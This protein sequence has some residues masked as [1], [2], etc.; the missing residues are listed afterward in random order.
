MIWTFRAVTA[1]DVVKLT[2]AETAQVWE[3]SNAVSGTNVIINNARVIKTDVGATNGV[4]HVIDSV[5]LPR[6]PHPR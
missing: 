2:S 6:R 5:L 4:I 1:A 3:L